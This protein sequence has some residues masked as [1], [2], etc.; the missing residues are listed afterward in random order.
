MLMASRELTE[1]QARFVAIYRQNG[2][3]G[4]Q[5]AIDAGYS[6]HTAEVTA[7]KLLRH[8]KV[9]GQLQ[10]DTEAALAPLQVTA[11]TVQRELAL[12]AFGRMGSF[13]E[14]GKLLEPYEL[15]E[16]EQARLSSIKVT[17]EK[18]VATTDGVT[19]I[20]VQQSVIEYKTFD[21]VRSLELLGKHLGMFTERVAVSADVSLLE[22]CRAIEAREKER[23]ANAAAID[24]EVVPA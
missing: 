3:N 21:K 24:T 6:A 5:A 20:S 22:V 10:A 14:T 23:A 11:D 1:R 16:A 9:R 7:S 4:K 19:E 8:G 2:G 12:I 15:P 13:Y 18:T 17:N